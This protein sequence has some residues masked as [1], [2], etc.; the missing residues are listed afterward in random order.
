M[1]RFALFVAVGLCMIAAP[2]G[3]HAELPSATLA[4]R[5]GVNAKTLAAVNVGTD[6]AWPLAPPWRVLRGFEAPKTH[7]S[8]G[9]RGIDLA[10]TP[11]DAVFAPAA[12]T[13]Y[14]AGMVAGRP[15]LTLQPADGLLVSFEPVETSLTKGQAVNRGEQVAMVVSGGHCDG[16]CIHFGVRVDGEYV[17][18]LL[19]FGG[20][21]RAVLLPLK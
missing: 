10:A 17:S 13:V 9:H 6:W 7:Y 11:A 15:V 4:N 12:S 14:F 3:A 16:R 21:P 20:V 19:Y 18:P 2:T 5:T 8:A 1:R